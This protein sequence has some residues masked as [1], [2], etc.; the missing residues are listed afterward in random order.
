MDDVLVGFVQALRAAGIRVSSSE[1]LDAF[2][3]S[4]HAGIR[5]RSIMKAAMR[6]ALVKQ[7][8]DIP[9]FDEIFDRYFS[10]TVE[11]MPFPGM[12]QGDDDEQ[13]RQERLKAHEEFMQRLREAM[14]RM[15]RQPLDR[16][17]DA[18]MAG[19]VTVITSEMLEHMTPEQLQQLENML[20]RGRL[21]RHI[22]D[23]MGW[24]KLQAE[25]I[26]LARDLQQA[27]EFELAQEVRERL[28]ELQELFPKWVANQ[29]NDA[30]EK[31]NANPREPVS[32]N[33][34]QKD[35][36]RFTESEIRAM[37]E[38]VDQLARKLREDFSRRMQRGGFKR[39]DV[40]K[41][42][43][44]SYKTGGVPMELI[45]KEHRRNKLRLA[46][47]CDVSSSVRNA[48]RFMLQLVYSLQQQKGRV[49]SF[50]FIAD[51]DEVSDYFERNSVDAAVDMATGEANI[52][53]WAH[54]DFGNTFK[55]FLDEYGDSI[56]SR[57]TVIVLGDGRSNFYDPHLDALTEIRRRSRQV[58]WLNPES[59]WSWG[60][61]DSIIDLYAQE[62][63]MLT[64][65][66]NLEQLTAVMEHLT[67]S[68]V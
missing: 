57:T 27:G 63:D 56:N 2:E 35:F 32:R 7:Q 42:L 26:D 5:D 43:R 8:Q 24:Q 33:L 19:N 41:T 60:S 38:I 54:S 16:L 9:T 3:A 30:Y 15:G 50:V 49:R 68:V 55:Q 64:E 61:G 28:W 52:R 51:V 67:Q 44:A 21:T 62:T 58:I 6:S 31:M 48:S 40:S 47:L 10:P 25:M 29:V 20:Q 18:L 46:I 45:F 13:S 4:K 11:P 37:E 22:L 34:E 53:Y 14:E 17:T 23:E 65:C 36:A 12:G 66:R 1:A 59:Q 39:L